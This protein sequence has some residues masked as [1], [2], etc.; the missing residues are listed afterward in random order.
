MQTRRFRLR[1][2]EVEAV[3]F[4]GENL[5]EVKAFIA[6][7]QSSSIT[8]LLPGDEGWNP[9]ISHADE[10]GVTFSVEEGEWIIAPGLCLMQSAEFARNYVEV[11]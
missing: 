4:T 6:S 8:L 7:H 1:V 11:T 5:D 3:Q 2:R 10:E 9:A